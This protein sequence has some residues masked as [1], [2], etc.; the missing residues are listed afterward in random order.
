MPEAAKLGFGRVF[1]DH[2]VVSR[3]TPTERWSEL[4]VVERTPLTLEPSAM[5]LHYSQSVF[6]GLK[7]YRQPDGSVAIFRPDMNAQRFQRSARR[8]A[9]PELS[10]S[11]F[12]RSL[13]MLVEVDSPAVPSGDE[14][15]LYL[16]PLM[17]G[18]DPFIGVRPSQ[19]VRYLVIASPVDSYF[20]GGVHP[21][22][23]WLAEEYV[24]ATPGGTGAAKTGGNY[25]AAMAAQQRALAEGCE[26][27]LFLDALERRWLEELGGMN[28]FLV[29][30]DGTLITPTLSGTILEGVTRDSIITLAR[31]RGRSVE[32]RQVSFDE[33]RAASLQAGSSR[34]SLAGLQ[35]SSHPSDA[36]SGRA[37]SC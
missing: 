14:Q 33:W 4:E 5:V 17:F 3:W 35:R 36:S 16:R 8:L 27:V 19:D 26:Q 31:D 21:V 6:E 22:S 29:A 12:I 2:M 13:D 28:V 25:A 10:E 37:A 18:I 9:L 20:A 32:E 23:I 7:G 24:R 15:S 1:T 11:E 30:A 34:H